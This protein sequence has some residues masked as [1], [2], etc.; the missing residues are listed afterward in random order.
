[1]R[2]RNGPTFRGVIYGVN[3]LDT[4]LY[5]TLTTIDGR[6]VLY[7][8]AS[9]KALLSKKS[10]LFA[11]CGYPRQPDCSHA[12][13]GMGL[14]TCVLAQPV[15]ILSVSGDFPKEVGNGCFPCHPSQRS[16]GLPIE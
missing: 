4:P 11:T 3:Q 9:V 7:E 10:K 5:L 15:R 1:M 6:L 8:Q 16:V 12:Q 14:K 2:E 13:I